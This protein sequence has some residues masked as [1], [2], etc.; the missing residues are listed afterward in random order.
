[1]IQA[2]SWTT[3]NI[4]DLANSLT[5]AVSMRFMSQEQ[6]AFVWKD[7]LVK[8][9]LLPVKSKNYPSLAASSVG[10]IKKV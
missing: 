2:S 10:D 7:S 5:L 6:A 9:G 8:S 3:Q 1:M 4:L